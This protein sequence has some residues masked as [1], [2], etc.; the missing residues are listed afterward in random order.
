[1]K[2]GILKHYVYRKEINEQSNT[3]RYGTRSL[4]AE[5]DGLGGIV[6]SLTGQAGAAY[7]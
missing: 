6:R 5:E 4:F 3:A 1:M 7:N 2:S